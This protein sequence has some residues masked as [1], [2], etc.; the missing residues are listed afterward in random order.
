MGTARDKVIA[1]LNGFSISGKQTADFSMFDNLQHLSPGDA[2]KVAQGYCMGICIDWTRRVLAGKPL[3]TEGPGKI[4]RQ[5]T[6]QAAIYRLTEIGK[7]KHSAANAVHTRIAHLYSAHVRAQLNSFRFNPDSTVREHLRDIY[8]EKS[9]M[10]PP[11]DATGPQLHANLKQFITTLD[12]NASK[13]YT[14]DDAETWVEFM[15]TRVDSENHYTQP[16]WAAMVDTM[17]KVLLRSRLQKPSTR[18]FNNIKVLEAAEEKFYGNQ[19]VKDGVSHVL[20]LKQFVQNTV[21]VLG[22]GLIASG[23]NSAHGVAV[24][25]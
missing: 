15:D 22:F 9:R 19:S 6:R 8:Q 18:P 5:T 2:G 25:Q 13:V 12:S 21:L 20:Q 23:K 24:C 10:T 11:P 1:Q 7:V 17:D 16:G 3:F 14:M 4:T